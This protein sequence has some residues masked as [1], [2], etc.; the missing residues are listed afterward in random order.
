MRG[1]DWQEGS[2]YTSNYTTNSSTYKKSSTHNKSGS[3]FSIRP[4]DLPGY[5]NY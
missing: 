2:A 3:R 5:K 4:K 1:Q